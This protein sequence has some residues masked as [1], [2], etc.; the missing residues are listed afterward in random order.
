[1]F[2]YLESYSEN[3]LKNPAILVPVCWFLEVLL[4]PSARGLVK[5]QSPSDNEG[6]FH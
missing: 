6:N 4:R 1:M 5:R 2:I 3:V